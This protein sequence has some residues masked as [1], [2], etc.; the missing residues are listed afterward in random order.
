MSNDSNWGEKIKGFTNN[1]IDKFYK[2]IMGDFADIDSQDYEY[3]CDR[4]K[5]VDV[6]MRLTV[7]IK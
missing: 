2:L 5:S 7:K 1:L 3:A 6:K 4:A